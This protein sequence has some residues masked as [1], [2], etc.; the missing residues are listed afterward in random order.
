VPNRPMPIFLAGALA[1]DVLGF[2]VILLL[3]KS[4][5]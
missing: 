5:N 2:A 4:M 3:W 1:Y